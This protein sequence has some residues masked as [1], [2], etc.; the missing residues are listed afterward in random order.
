MWLLYYAGIYL[1]VLG[2]RITSLWNKKSQKWLLGRKGLLSYLKNIPPKANPRIWFHVASL[3]EFEQGRAVI[4]KIKNE[5]PE[6]EIILSF[7]S[8]SGYL[9][10]KNYPHAT[11]IYLPADLPGNAK[12]YLEA[13]QPDLAVF[14]K[15]DLWP[16][17]LKQL[18]DMQI[19]AILI[20]AYWSADRKI[21][22][23]SLPITISLLKGFK[24]IF[25]QRSEHL[26]YFF[27]KGFNNIEVAGDTRIDRSLLLPGEVNK[28]LPAVLDKKVFDLVCGSTWKK[29]EEMI[30][31]A[32]KNLNLKVIIAPHDVSSRNIERLIKSFSFP[33]QLLSQL[34]KEDP[35]K[36]VLV[37]DSIGILSVLYSIGKV[38]YVGGGFGKGIHNILEPAAHKKPVVFG[39]VFS[40][41]PEAIDMV[42]NGG[43]LCVRNKD[44]L[45]HALQDLQNTE[46]CARMGHHAFTY[47]KEHSGA[48]EIVS[49]YILES[50]PYTL[51]E[52]DYKGGF[53]ESSK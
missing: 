29:D 44:E 11:V 38:A 18:A 8:P 3:G 36:N 14:V 25:L 41:F 40:R 9:P 12:Q 5:R 45:V 32:I 34:R 13:L 43:A 49:Q 1:M 22:S 23:W 42:S 19:P 37:I 51:K 46:R 39:P 33:Y 20:S 50:I 53:T 24:K 4:E 31:H 15:Y 21:S 17:Y 7:F 27:K 52:N 48:S 30:V 47:L 10:K 26:D 28:R 35:I 2:I 6:T 16:G